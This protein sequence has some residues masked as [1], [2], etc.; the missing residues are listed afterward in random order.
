MICG[1]CSEYLEGFSAFYGGK[2]ALH[3]WLFELLKSGPE[4]EK[5]LFRNVLFFLIISN[6]RKYYKE[7][8]KGRMVIDIAL[9]M[10]GLKG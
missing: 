5:M 4:R 10:K 9:L 7:I 6:H 8:N 2:V 1:D 3:C